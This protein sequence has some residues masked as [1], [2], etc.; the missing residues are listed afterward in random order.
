M[1]KKMIFLVLSGLLLIL[2]S[3][4]VMGALGDNGK[5]HFNVPE[6]NKNIRKLVGIL[7]A[8]YL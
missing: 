6:N 1:K 8:L 4:N 7:P 3:G 5:I 2:I